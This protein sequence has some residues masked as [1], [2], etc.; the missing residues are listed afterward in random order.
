LWGNV[1]VLGATTQSAAPQLAVSSEWV[2]AVWRS[3]AEGEVRHIA[4]HALSGNPTILALKAFHPYNY[5]LLPATQDRFHLLWLDRNLDG[6]TPRLFAALIGADAVALLGNSTLA[7]QAVWRYSTLTDGAGGV[8]VVWSGGLANQPALYTQTIDALGRIRFPSRLL[9]NADYPAVAR[10]PDGQVA[11][12]WLQKGMV[13]R[14]QL[15]ATETGETLTNNATLTNSITLNLGDRLE[16]FTVAHDTTHGY[17][18]WQ[19]VRANGSAEVWWTSGA[20]AET[21]WAAPQRW[22]MPTRGAAFVETGFNSG[23]VIAPVNDPQ[24]IAWAT[25]LNDSQPFVPVAVNWGS[26][27][28]VAYLRGGRVA[29]YQ[30]LTDSG[31][32]L[33]APSI[34]TDQANHLYV[35]W[36]AMT[37]QP[38][39]ALLLTATR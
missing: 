6:E 32:L 2:M 34:T 23:S 7:D 30:T 11:V 14:G 18:F 15:G 28:G 13:Q 37:E 16:R 17:L 12:Y 10:L 26:T 21:T 9:A 24:P 20:L 25:A 35:A 27:L 19:L 8:R 29:G 39:A 22:Q 33:A 38:L 4:R 36:S 31:K 1:T 3:T 5:Q